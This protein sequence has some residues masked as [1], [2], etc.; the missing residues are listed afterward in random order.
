MSLERGLGEV[1]TESASDRVH[2]LLG[3]RI[4]HR[5]W[6][7]GG[8]LWI[9]PRPGTSVSLHLSVAAGSLDQGTAGGVR[10]PAG[11]AHFLEHR[12]FEKQD[13]DLSAQ[14]AA[15]GADI[16]AETGYTHTS[17]TCVA[18]IDHVEDC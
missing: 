13:G 14:F 1:G 3:E 2:P 7:N 16:D 12:L 9:C 5:R 18:Q 4:C 11:I 6:P 10:L 15:L 8:H 17:F